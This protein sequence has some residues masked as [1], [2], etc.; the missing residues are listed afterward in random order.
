MRR[1]QAGGVDEMRLAVIQMSKLR[2]KVFGY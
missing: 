1:R 2:I